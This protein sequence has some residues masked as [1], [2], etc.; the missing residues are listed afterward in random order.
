MSIVSGSL[1][2]VKAKIVVGA[3]S[4]LLVGNGWAGLFE[5]EEARRAILDLRQQI[6]TVKRESDKKIADEVRRSTEDEAQLRRSLIELQNQLEGLRA[7]LAKLRGQDEQIAR[8]VA[9]LQ[10]KQKDMLQATEDRIRKLEPTRVT[11]DGREFLAEPSEKRDFDAGLAIFRRGE[12]ANAQ[13]AFVDFLNRYSQ[14][15]YRP[16]ALFWLGNAQYATK[17]YKEALIN[18][19]SLLTQAPDHVRAPEAMLAIANCQNELK[20]PKAARKTLEDLVAAHPS[21]EAASAA[22]ERLARLK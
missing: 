19:R 13:L 17:D 12:F 7:E 6:D 5:D 3:I 15:G 21:S 11:V 1:V 10:R 4:L 20:E 9:D 18:F 16:S 14:T 2:G 8:E 22:K